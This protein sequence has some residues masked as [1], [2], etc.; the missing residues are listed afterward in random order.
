MAHV[1]STACFL[2]ST[3]PSSDRKHGYINRKVFCGRG[4]SF[5]SF[6]KERSLVCDIFLTAVGLTPDDRST[7]HIY[8]QT[9]HGTT[10]ST[11]TIHVTTQLTNWKSAGRAPSLQFALQQRKKHVKTSEKK[12]KPQSSI[13][14]FSDYVLVLC[15]WSWSSGTTETCCRK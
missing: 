10:Q 12:K 3:W 14:Y 15:T 1:F 11:Q 4:L 5:L 13:S 2:R 6:V 7:V 9:I 8:T